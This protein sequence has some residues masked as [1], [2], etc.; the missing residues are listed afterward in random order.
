[1]L[2]NAAT[3][4]RIHQHC[5]DELISNLIC[6]HSKTQQICQCHTLRALSYTQTLHGHSLYHQ[7]ATARRPFRNKT[8]STRNQWWATAGQQPVKAAEGTGC[9]HAHSARQRWNIIVIL[10]TMWSYQSRAVT[11]KQCF[12]MCF[13]F[14]LL[15]F[16]TSPNSLVAFA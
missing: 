13:S 10:E 6:L 7:A 9:K 5:W 15:S 3:Y 2:K 11:E 14:F 8:E 12:L 16:N 4:T 1:M